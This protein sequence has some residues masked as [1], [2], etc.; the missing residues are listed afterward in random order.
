MFI[1][2]KLN[3]ENISHHSPANEI[4]ILEA[5]AASIPSRSG[6][7]SI[8]ANDKISWVPPPR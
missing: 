3:T 1:L 7:R 2:E 8:I 5:K 6:P 4:A